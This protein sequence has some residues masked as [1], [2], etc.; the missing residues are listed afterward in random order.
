MRQTLQERI[1]TNRKLTQQFI[2]RLAMFRN[3]PTHPLLHDH[4]LTGRK[5]ELRSFSITGDIRVVYH[6][7]SSKTVILLD[8]GSHAQVY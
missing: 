4:Q 1:A 2:N 3:N 5:Q 6:N 7:I 8:I